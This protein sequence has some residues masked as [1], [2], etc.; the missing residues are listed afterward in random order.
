MPVRVTVTL[1][2]DIFSELDSVAREEGRTRS[3]VVREA[4]AG[5]LAGRTAVA[6]ATARSR[7]IDDGISWLEGVATNSGATSDAEREDSLTVLRELR[8]VA[9]DTAGGPIPRARR[10]RAKRRQ[11]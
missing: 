6:E 7:A 1:P 5:Y 3:D 8:G 2:E 9:E 11:P 4:A 10:P